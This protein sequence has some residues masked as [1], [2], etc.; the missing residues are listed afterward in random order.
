MSPNHWDFPNSKPQS[1]RAH[2]GRTVALLSPF[3]VCRYASD[4]E[5]SAFSPAG[6][7]L[8][9][10]PQPLG[11]QVPLE[12]LD[13]LGGTVTT[14]WRLRRWRWKHPLFFRPRQNVLVRVLRAATGEK[15][16]L[17]ARRPSS[18]GTP[19]GCAKECRNG[20]WLGIGKRPRQYVVHW[21]RQW[22]WRYSINQKRAKERQSISGAK[23][24]EK[25][26]VVAYR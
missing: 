12:A 2:T 4:L 11:Y 3:F 25:G 8:A 15:T 21:V 18:S 6:E 9:P 5:A 20:W 22:G 26:G 19:K 14:Y 1:R 16:L 7:G 13:T 23:L 10:K 17:S 24:E